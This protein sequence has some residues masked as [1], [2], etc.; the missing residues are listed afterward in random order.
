MCGPDDFELP[1]VPYRTPAY[2]LAGAGGDGDYVL[3]QFPITYGG[4]TYK[5]WIAYKQGAPPK[6]V[7]LIFP[8]YSGLKQFDKDQA[9]FMAKLGYVVSTA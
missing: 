8:N 9:M 3:E 7:V 5:S 1:K 4:Y 2:L 6:P